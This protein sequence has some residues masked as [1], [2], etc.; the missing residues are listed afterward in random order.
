MKLRTQAAAQ[1]LT[2][3]GENGRRVSGRTL[4]AWRRKGPADPGERGPDFY[5]DPQS[6]FC[7]YAKEDLDRWINE[8]ASRLVR[9]GSTA[10]PAWL[11]RAA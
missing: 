10:Q 4:Q 5:R 7:Y 3:H 9:R 2:E 11:D 1:Y 8:R 6:G